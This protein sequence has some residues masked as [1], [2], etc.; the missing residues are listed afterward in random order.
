MK[1]DF[2]NEDPNFERS[3]GHRR[4]NVSIDSMGAGSRKISLDDNNRPKCRQV[5]V[6]GVTS[7]QI[8][9]RNM[10]EYGNRTEEMATKKMSQR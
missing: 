3:S 9:G 2:Q 7:S 8:C 6:D 10:S 5:P 1:L 4:R